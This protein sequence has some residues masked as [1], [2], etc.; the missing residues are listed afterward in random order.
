MPSHWKIGLPGTKP[1]TSRYFCFCTEERNLDIMVEADS[2]EAAI[3]L[4]DLL[5]PTYGQ[6]HRRSG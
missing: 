6:Y 2:D 5:V 4:A 1:L 3:A